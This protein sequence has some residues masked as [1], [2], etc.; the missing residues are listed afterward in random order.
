MIS[1]LTNGI[2]VSV[3]TRYEGSIMR[4]E[5]RFFAF[6]YKISIE[7]Q[8]MSTIQLLTRKWVIKDALNAIQIV[9][10]DGVIGLQPILKPLEIHEYSSGCYLRSSIGSMQGYYTMRN[11]DNEEQ[12]KVYIPNFKLN[13]PFVLN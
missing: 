12:F 10:G 9:E 5:H 4:N 2:Q 3:E 8:S 7:N 13:T 11:S 1:K 6:S